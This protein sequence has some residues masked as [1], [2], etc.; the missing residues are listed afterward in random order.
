VKAVVKKCHS[1][2]GTKLQK[3]K[4]VRSSGRQEWEQKAIKESGTMV[5]DT[6]IYTW[7]LIH[8]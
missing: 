2:T 5:V 4:C 6:V 7:P 3:E 1:A 8:Q